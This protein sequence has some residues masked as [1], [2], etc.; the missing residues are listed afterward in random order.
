[1]PVLRIFE[2]IDRRNEELGIQQDAL[3]GEIKSVELLGEVIRQQV[4][5]QPGS[6]SSGEAAVGLA[7]EGASE[8]SG[9]SARPGPWSRGGGDYVI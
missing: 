1:M 7:A 5:R 3:S 8:F 6:C 2:S 4:Y 9:T